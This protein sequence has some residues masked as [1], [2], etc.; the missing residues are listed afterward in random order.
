MDVDCF[1]LVQTRQ[2]NEHYSNTANVYLNE[3]ILFTVNGTGR[4]HSQAGGTFFLKAGDV[5]SAFKNND[6]LGIVCMVDAWP[7]S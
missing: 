3:N 4:I 6:A 2:T 5:I 1:A 7:L